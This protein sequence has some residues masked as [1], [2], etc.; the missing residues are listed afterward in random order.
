[1]SNQVQTTVKTLTK[2][3]TIQEAISIANEIERHEAALKQM[4]DLLKGFVEKTGLPV[5]TGEK[6]WDFSVNTSWEFSPDNLKALASE[7]FLMG[8]N[9]WDFLDLGSKSISKL[10]LAEDVL[11]QYGK[12]KDSKR[13]ASRKSEVMSKK[14]SA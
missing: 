9:P 12:P 13:F 3:S 2:I 8:Y 6:I 5:E 11:K 7:I 1:M 14:K 4:K 10:N